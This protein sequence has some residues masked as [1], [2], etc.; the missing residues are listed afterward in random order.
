[1]NLCSSS[2]LLSSLLPLLSS[3]LPSTLPSQ[4]VNADIKKFI[5]EEHGAPRLFEVNT[6]IVGKTISTKALGSTSREDVTDQ[7]RLS[8]RVH[9]SVLSVCLSLFINLS[10]TSLSLH[11]CLSVC[12]SLFINLSTPLV[13]PC[14]T[15]CLSISVHL[16][17]SLAF[18]L[19]TYHTNYER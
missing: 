3:I 10:T 18:H 12:E 4:Q 17:S 15:V 9:L 14:T 11:N 5:I 2:T 7:V 19:S 1:M 13:C 16:C 6:S 8:A